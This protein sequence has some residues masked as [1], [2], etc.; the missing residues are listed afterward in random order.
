MV[1]TFR[2]LQVTVITNVFHSCL[3]CSLVCSYIQLAMSAGVMP[4]SPSSASKGFSSTPRKNKNKRD[5]VSKT[6]EVLSGSDVLSEDDTYSLLSPIY[7]DSFDSDEDL[8]SE[9]EHPQRTDTSSTQWEIPRRASSPVRYFQHS[10]IHFIVA[11]DSVECIWALKK[12][13]STN[14]M[15]IWSTVKCCSIEMETTCPKLIKEQVSIQVLCLNQ[16]WLTSGLVNRNSICSN[17]I[18]CHYRHS[19]LCRYMFQMWVAK[20]TGKDNCGKCSLASAQCLG[21]VAVGQS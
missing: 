17:N 14:K 19:L 18:I 9:T 7:H 12:R 21:G 10:V 1:F 20:S 3:L 8:D 6:A 15:C 13:K 5:N 11:S 16:V 2:A 4:R